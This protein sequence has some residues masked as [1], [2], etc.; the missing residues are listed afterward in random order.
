MKCEGLNQISVQREAG[1]AAMRRGVGIVAWMGRR[2]DRPLFV[3]RA[4]A[5]FES[6]RLSYLT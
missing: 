2:E 3:R 6:C 1:R 4:A 5:E